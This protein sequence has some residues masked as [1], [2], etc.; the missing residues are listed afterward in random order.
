M[1]AAKG[2]DLF[3]ILGD[4]GFGHE[5]AKAQHVEFFR[6]VANLCR[7][8]DHEGFGMN[9]LQHVGG[10]NVA[11]IEGWVL[12]HQDDMLGG[13]INFL[14]RGRCEMIALF[15]AHHHPFAAGRQLTALQGQGLH[16][17]MK[18]AVAAPLCLKHHGES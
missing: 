18:Q 2:I 16:M 1:G 12:P 11:H 7:I 3:H 5:L 9:G 8:I 13:E 4:Q 17:V 6:G 14:L 10:G 15:I